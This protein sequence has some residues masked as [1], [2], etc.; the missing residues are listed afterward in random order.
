MSVIEIGNNRIEPAL[1]HAAEWE[2]VARTLPDEERRAC[3]LWPSLGPLR[4]RGDLAA[5][6]TKA[7]QQLEWTRDHPEW[8]LRDW[9]MSAHA[10]A[11]WELAAV[12]L[13]DGSLARVRELAERGS[14]VAR[15]VGDAEMDGWCCGVLVDLGFLCGEPDLARAA[16]EHAVRIGESLSAL[17]RISAHGALGIQLL[18]DGRADQAVESREYA[19]SLTSN[20]NRNFAPHL[21]QALA[22]AC[23]AAGDPVRSRALA[24]TI[25][26]DCLEIGARVNAIEAAVALSA[27]L[28]AHAGA[29]AAPRMDEVLATAE[30]LIAETGAR[31]LTPFVLME[32]AGLAE[33]R[34]EMQQREAY[35]RG[36]LEGFTRMGA[37]GRA[38]QLERELGS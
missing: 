29:A 8:G 2:R 1:A 7:L 9:S 28:R 18:L 36:A 25:L 3:A 33:L 12:E 26:A 38:A 31:N 34:E 13:Y 32:R 17:S 11:L 20:G 16:V 10:G 23:L 35:L 30:R 22:Q 19:L 27:A 24:E 4:F 15:H 5:A 14:E 37:T 6:R 21:R